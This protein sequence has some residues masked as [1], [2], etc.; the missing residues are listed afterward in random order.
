MA[1][2]CGWSC[3]CRRCFIGATATDAGSLFWKSPVWLLLLLL[4]MMMML[5]PLLLHAPARRT[6]RQASPPAG[7]PAGVGPEPARRAPRQSWRDWPNWQGWCRLQET[8][9]T[10][11]VRSA[12]PEWPLSRALSLSGSLSPCHAHPHPWP[13]A[14]PFPAIPIPTPPRAHPRIHPATLKS[15]SP[16]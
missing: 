1:V 13:P 4:M 11:C 15:G 12:I 16:A 6:F 14:P 2:G 8:R 7:R 3:C 5:R 10:T 9:E